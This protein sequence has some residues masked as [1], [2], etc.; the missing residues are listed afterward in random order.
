MDL[1]IIGSNKE[2]K[3]KQGGESVSFLIWKLGERN[4][5][6][7]DVGRGRP[8]NSESSPVQKKKNAFV[9]IVAVKCLP[10]SPTTKSKLP[11][12]HYHHRNTSKA[13]THTQ[14]I[15]T[16]QITQLTSLRISPYS[17]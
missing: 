11:H 1:C 4:K 17:R 12:H 15:N 3:W 10:S 14:N 9:D 16:L 7:R 13:Q 6:D 5:A 8:V 2:L